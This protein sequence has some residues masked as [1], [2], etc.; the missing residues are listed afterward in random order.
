MQRLACG[1]SSVLLVDMGGAFRP[2][3]ILA[4]LCSVREV[5]VGNREVA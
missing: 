4:R 5:L 2:A 3:L 1:Y